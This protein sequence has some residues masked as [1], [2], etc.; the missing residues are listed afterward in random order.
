YTYNVNTGSSPNNYSIWDDFF[1]H[2]GSSQAR[3]TDGDGF[4]DHLDL[5]SDNDG[6]PDNIEAQTTIG[7]VAPSGTVNSSG[8]E[9]GL[10][11][12]YGTGLDIVN[13]D[14]ID[15]VDLLDADSDNDGT[16]DIQENGMANV[17]SGSD[18]DSDGLD[19]N[20]EGANLNDPTDINDEINDPTDL[21]ILPDS[22]SDLGAFGDLDF[23]DAVSGAVGALN[24][25]G[26][27]DYF[28]VPVSV[29]NNLDEYTVSFWFKPESVPVSTVPSDRT[30]IF[31]QKNV[32]EVTMRNISGNIYLFSGHF[33][34]TTQGGAVGTQIDFNNWIHYTATVDHNNNIL[35][36]YINGQDQG[37][38]VLFTPRN[39]NGNPLR[40]GSK[41][42][43]Q[44]DP[45]EENFHG[46]IDEV[47]IFDMK[48]TP[49]QIRRMVYQEI[50]NNTGNVH[51]SV[52]G[53]DIVDSTTGNSIP[54]TNLISHYPM[55]NISGNIVKDESLNSNTAD[56]YNM[57]GFLPQT[58]PM[59][60]ETIVD[61]AWTSEATWLHGNVWDIEDIPNN[62]DWSIVHIKD[63]VTTSDSHT[64]LGMFID[65]GMTLAVN[66]DNSITNNWY[67]QLDG[68]LDLAGDSQLVQTEHSDLVTSA[69]GK[70]L[71]RQEGN[72]DVH[73]YNYWTSPVGATGVTTLSD[74]N[75][76]TNNTNNS[77]FNLDMLK[78]GLGTDIQF[79][80][81]FDEAGKISRS[82]LYNFQN[83]I[84]YY[85]WVNI[86]ETTP[87]APGVGYTQKGTGNAGTE[88]QYLFEGK[89]NN[90][91]ILITADDVTDIYEGANGG[92]SVQDTTVVTS[93]I[94][95][96]YPS[97][98][99]ADEFIRDNIDFD[100]GGAN[101]II[102]GTILLWEQWAGDTH[103][104]SEYE[105]G[106]GFINL[107]ST[108]RAYQHPDI[109][110]ADPENP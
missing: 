52:I 77:A 110:I 108:E 107:T 27:D 16:P 97:A 72:N 74:N 100:N 34:N 39:F 7:Y 61:G 9:I 92:E 1:V 36:H 70:I 76:P 5:D 10:W 99:D 33:Y 21:T 44:P 12:N 19:N 31:G 80:S 4:Y 91:T 48:L 11:D 57:S 95:N 41:R 75:G 93:L 43:T 86:D 56:L 28:E 25:D 14:N 42:D 55:N 106:Y 32:Y 2:V 103:Y 87:I 98:L 30:F 88:Q 58:A 109:V 94:G 104:L 38:Q 15:A 50:E 47:R 13:T 90:G 83:G 37:G 59:P 35:R 22:D 73:W 89:P 101:P 62:K 23:R 66:G 49:D 3:N 79:T 45:D 8:P 29:I 26:V 18:T 71:R 20:F 102:N 46:W 85:D 82:W 40:I 78:D 53:K 63:N 17:L 68:T 65:S 24:F 105:G 64:Q 60:Y 6:I 67:L 84:T 69:A 54:W 51:G 81:A 96:P